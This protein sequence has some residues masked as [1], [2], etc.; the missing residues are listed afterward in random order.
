MLPPESYEREFEEINKLG[1]KC[2]LSFDAKTKEIVL[3]CEVRIDEPKPPQVNLQ[4]MQEEILKVGE[5]AKLLKVGHKTIY[6]M[7]QSGDLPAFKVRGQWRFSRK[8]L[9]QW[10]Y[11]QKQGNQFNNFAE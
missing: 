8:D 3:S 4:E 7:A 10:M 9:D 11:R 2:K 6:T 5:V 1:K